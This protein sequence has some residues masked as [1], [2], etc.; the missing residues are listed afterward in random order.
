MYTKTSVRFLFFFGSGHHIH[1]TWPR[2]DLT[3][4]GGK[5]PKRKTTDCVGFEPTN[6][7]SGDP[8]VCFSTIFINVGVGRCVGFGE[9]H[10]ISE[11]K[12]KIS[13][14]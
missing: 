7:D 11:K 12:K 8:I 1:P 2:D 10:L 3:V 14:R 6:Q 13:T 4:A 5:H 9:E